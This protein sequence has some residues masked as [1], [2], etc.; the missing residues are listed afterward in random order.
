M[1]I[2]V[3]SDSHG[4]GQAVVLAL[5]LFEENRVETILHC[6]DIDDEATVSLF[7]DI[8]THFVQGNCDTEP[9][10]LAA[11]AHAVGATFHGRFADLEFAGKRI[12]VAHGDDKGRL[13]EAVQSGL[14][15]F[16]FYGHTHVAERHTVGRTTVVN[17]GALYRARPKTVA[18]MD[19]PKGDVRFLTV[20]E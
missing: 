7:S 16:V 10:H 3:L 4:N 15:D 11:V 20:C 19:L 9:A 2:G 5:R 6:G 13:A 14:Y 12:A 1:V 17:P 8:P 18:L